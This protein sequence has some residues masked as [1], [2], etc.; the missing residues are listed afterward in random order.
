MDD[1]KAP[2]PEQGL[3]FLLWSNPMAEKL[4]VNCPKWICKPIAPLR[5][6]M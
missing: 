2:F 4:K 1:I 5:H 3:G 6:Q